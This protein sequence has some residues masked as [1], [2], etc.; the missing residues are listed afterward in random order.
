MLELSRYSLGV[1]D[2]FGREGN[3]QL[4]ALIRFQQEY[5]VTVVPVW[6][7]SNRE[8]TLVGTVPQDVRTEA[9]NAV[10]ALG[11][12]KPYHVDADHIGVD[13]VDPF[14]QPSDFF[15]I[16]VADFI[17]QRAPQP[18]IDDFCKG[19]ASLVGSLEIPGVE[20]ALSISDDQLKGVAAK[21]LAAVNQAVQVY[22]HILGRKGSDFITEISMDETTEPQ[23]PAE[24][25]I[26]LAMIGD[27]GIP[28]QTIAPKFSGKFLKGIDYVGD[29]S[30]FRTEFRNDLAVVRYAIAKFGLPTNLKLSV[31]SGSDKFRLYPIINEAV[32]DANTGLHLKTAGTTWLEEAIGLAEAGGDGLRLAKQIY[33]QA[34]ADRAN[35]VKPYATVTDIDESRLPSPGVVNSWTS[36]QFVRALRHNKR[37]EQ[38]NLHLRQLVHIGYPI[39]A[40]MGRQFMD[41]LQANRAAIERNVTV[42]LYERHLTPLFV[43]C[44]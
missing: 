17:G 21:Y 15:T 34:Y 16:D 8:H 28:I 9:T 44:R 12:E 4:E 10:S 20:G 41:A 13:N 11:W 42:N 30:K 31:H 6:N 22:N 29:P 32:R 14:I 26:I 25:L 5:G 23:V 3:A 19:N 1:G 33:Q 37:D 40:Q 39:A 43:G 24:L 38:Y 18:S 35:L 27:R 7:K 36:E 2:R